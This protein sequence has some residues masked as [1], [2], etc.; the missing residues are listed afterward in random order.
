[1]EVAL[2]DPEADVAALREMGE[3]VVAACEC[4]Q[5][6]IEALLGFFQSRRGLTR[7][8]PVDISAI[9]AEALRTHDRQG[10]TSVETFEPALTAGDPYL[11]GLLVA[12]LVANSIH[13]N[14]PGGSIEIGTHTASGR[15]ILTV[16]NTGPLIPASELARLFQPFQR[17]ASQPRPAAAGVG[18]GLAIV[19]AIANAHEAVVCAQAQSGGGLRIDVGFPALQ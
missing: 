4:Q 12:N 14:V 17:L 3:R 11:V 5:R 18:L 19:Q 16:A 6:L 9:A 8:E 2:A 10:L 13:H 15:A 7:R 1:V